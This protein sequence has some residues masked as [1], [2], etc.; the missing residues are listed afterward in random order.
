RLAQPMRGPRHAS[1][2]ACRAEPIP[3][4]FLDHWTPV[5]ARNERLAVRRRRDRARKRLQDA[6]RD[7]LTRLG[8]R[9]LYPAVYDVRRP[10]AGRVAASQARP[11]HQVKRQPLA[12]AYRPAL[13]KGG[14]LG[15]GPGM[16]AVAAQA[17]DFDS[18]GRVGFDVFTRQRPLKERSERAEKV[19][20]LRRRR[21]AGVKAGEDK[22]AVPTL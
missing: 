19:A 21:R 1:R 7:A 14:K 3:E 13:L 15:C 20:G 16:E 8:G 17:V 11:Q 4:R 12:R 2:S 10:H 6:N 22:F 5:Q 9:K 18:G